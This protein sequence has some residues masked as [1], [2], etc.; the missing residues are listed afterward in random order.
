M[1]AAKK[2]GSL[3][4]DEAPPGA[5]D[6]STEEHEIKGPKRGKHM[7]GGFF[8][9]VVFRQFGVLAAETGRSKQDLLNE[10]LNDLFA[11]H[12]KPPIA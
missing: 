4:T 1:N 8:D 10:A 5:R 12:G 6:V 3:F 11:K 9:T 2:T 7:L